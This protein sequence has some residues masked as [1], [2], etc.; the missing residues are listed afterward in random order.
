MGSLIDIQPEQTLI[1]PCHRTR[2]EKRNRTEI[3]S[4]VPLLYSQSL[5]SAWWD[6]KHVESASII[7]MHGGP[8]L[9]RSLIPP[10]KTLS[11]AMF[12]FAILVFASSSFAQ[13]R[14]GLVV[15][16]SGDRFTARLTSI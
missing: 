13:S 3:S 15:P 6:R 4:T 11:L 7:S 12:L 8:A 1:A 2:T 14:P 10:Y 5:G 9:A 16:A